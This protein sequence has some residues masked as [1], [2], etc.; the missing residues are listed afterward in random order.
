MSGSDREN[1]RELWRIAAVAHELAYDAYQ[2][3][4]EGRQ[5]FLDELVG[6]LMNANRGMKATTAERM[7]RTSDAYK[8][9]I[10]QM[11]NFRREAA[12]LKIKMS[13]ADRRYWEAVGH[14]ANRRAEMKMTGFAR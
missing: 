9:Y 10:T 13:D 3:A 6:E 2:R 1:L 14:D 12:Q 8:D 5:I 11:H 4:K 7:A